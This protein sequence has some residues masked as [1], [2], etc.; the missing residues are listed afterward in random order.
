[1][2]LVSICLPFDIAC[3]KLIRANSGEQAVGFSVNNIAKSYNLKANIS[4][5]CFAL[6][7][8]TP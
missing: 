8:K 7:L 1:M 3:N 4:K 5:R 6:Y 2:A